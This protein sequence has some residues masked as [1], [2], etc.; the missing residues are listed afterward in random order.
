MLE[1]TISP[2]ETKR[3]REL[4]ERCGLE[5]DT[6]LVNVALSLLEWAVTMREGGGQIEAAN[7]TTQHRI[8]LSNSV[9]NAV[10]PRLDRQSPKH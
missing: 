1:I 2:A 7:Y 8:I 3:L 5:S 10:K 6:E 9:L 4:A